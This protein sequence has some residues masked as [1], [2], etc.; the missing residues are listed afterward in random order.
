[1]DIRD[2]LIRLGLVDASDVYDIPTEEEDPIRPLIPESGWY[3]VPSE[4]DI[5]IGPYATEE[6]AR[7]DISLEDP[8][9]PIDPSTAIVRYITVIGKNQDLIANSE[10]KEQQ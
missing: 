2:Q 5:I 10:G 1:M 9:N 6:E 7:A 4:D 8:F 3:V